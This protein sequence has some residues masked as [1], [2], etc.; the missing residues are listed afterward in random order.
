LEKEYHVRWKTRTGN[1]FPQTFSFFHRTIG[2]Y[3]N[4]LIGAGFHI[5]A[6]EE[7]RPV[8]DA[9]FFNREHRIPFFLVM[10]GEK[11]S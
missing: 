7:P 1:G 9:S 11:I 10:R 4:A 5:T 3:V 6:F 2:T 8:S